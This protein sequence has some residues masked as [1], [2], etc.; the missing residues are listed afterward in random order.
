MDLP[1]QPQ[2]VAESRR[3]NHGGEHVQRRRDAI[4][5][6]AKKTRKS[7]E[8]C[9]NLEPASKHLLWWET[10]CQSDDDAEAAWSQAVGRSKSPARLQHPRT[11]SGLL[12]G[13]VAMSPGCSSNR[14]TH[15]RRTFQDDFKDA[16][17]NSIPETFWDRT[18]KLAIMSVGAVRA[19]KVQEDPPPLPG[20]KT[21]EDV[22][23]TVGELRNLR[24]PLLACLFVLKDLVQLQ[25]GR[26]V[27]GA[28]SLGDVCPAM[29]RG[30]SSTPIID[31]GFFTFCFDFKAVTSDNDTR[32][33]RL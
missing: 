25:V 30:N 11:R 29:R 22:V 23:R 16:L 20:S 6:H 24:T 1:Q 27:L 4:M 14:Q 3:A 2:G 19:C 21:S 15:P 12:Q 28:K 18:P 8:K 31:R 10:D 17:V 32:V 9:K 33:S 26:V 13:E 7:H 5:D